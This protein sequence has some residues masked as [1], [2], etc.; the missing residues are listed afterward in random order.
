MGI[1]LDT[2]SPEY[3]TNFVN[4]QD[5]EQDK[6]YFFEVDLEYPQE[7]HDKH[8]AYPLAPEHVT[9]KE[10]MLS[11]HQRKLAMDLDVK[12]GGNK[13]CLTLLSQFEALPEAWSQNNR[14]ERCSQVG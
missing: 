13:L 9:I 5:D 7:L 1:T 14:S 11:D 4:N 3:W 10:S 8:D 6:G 12:I 2:T